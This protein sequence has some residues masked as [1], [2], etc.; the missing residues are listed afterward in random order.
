M[1][2]LHVGSELTQTLGSDLGLFGQGNINRISS[3]CAVSPK[4][5]KSSFATVLALSTLSSFSLLSY[6]L[7]IGTNDGISAV[8][9]ISALQS[10]VTFDK[11]FI[12]FPR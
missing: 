11:C 1:C 10:D 8:V 2:Y 4:V 12:L 7:K 9:R 5:A 6:S 3:V